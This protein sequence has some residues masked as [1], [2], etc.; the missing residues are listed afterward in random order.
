LQ[1]VPELASIP[2]SMQLGVAAQPGGQGRDAIPRGAKQ[3]FGHTKSAA[4]RSC[5]GYRDVATL[6]L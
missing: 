3:R 2:V 5:C 1:H 6:Q 4:D